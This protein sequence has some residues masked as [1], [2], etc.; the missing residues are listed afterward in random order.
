MEVEITNTASAPPPS[1]VSWDDI[2]S[3]PSFRFLN[4]FGAS[5]TRTRFHISSFVHTKTMFRKY[6]VNATVY[7]HLL[8]T[9]TNSACEHASTK[10]LVVSITR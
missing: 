6:T 7:I 2:L 1:L 10:T 4:T 5:S 9:R 8:K 3:P